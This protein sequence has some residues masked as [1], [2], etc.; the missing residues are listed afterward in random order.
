[1]KIIK[2]ILILILITPIIYAPKIE[3]KISKAMIVNLH[4]L[5]YISY[6]KNEPFELNFTFVNSGNIPF[7]ARGRLDIFNDSEKIFTGWS[8]ETI[9]KTGE[10]KKI[11]VH[12]YPYNTTGEFSGIL[13]VY[14]GTEIL[15]D[16]EFEFEVENTE[17]PKRTINITNLETYDEEMVLT[18]ESEKYLE[19]VIIIPTNYPS[20]WFFEQKE[21]E[22]LNNSEKIELIYEPSFWETGNLIT[23]QAVT[24]DGENYGE[25]TFPIEKEGFL[26]RFIYYS[27]KRIKAF[28]ENL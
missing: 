22:E 26:S 21:L 11:P 25:A 14:Y 16:E 13:K 9:F 4:K 2:L 3:V 23:F 6:V 27:S 1:M 8:E 19:D 28:L 10:M 20:G 17:L 15:E 12:W 5:D 24:R 7:K 18:L